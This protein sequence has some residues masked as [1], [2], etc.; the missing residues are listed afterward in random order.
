LTPRGW[1]EHYA[2]QV[3]LDREDAVSRLLDRL[4]D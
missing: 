2:E 1:Q 3:A 4:G